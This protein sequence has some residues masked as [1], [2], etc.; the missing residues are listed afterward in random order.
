[1][2]NNNEFNPTGKTVVVYVQKEVKIDRNSSVHASIYS[3]KDMKV[4]GKKNAVTDMKGLFI[5]PKVTSTYTH[6]N[7]DTICNSCQNSYNKVEADPIAEDIEG[8]EEVNNVKLIVYPTPNR[9]DFGVDVYSI[10]DG[11]VSV[12]VYDLTGK[13]VFNSG[14]M[15]LVGPT[16]IPIKLENVAKATYYVRTVVNGKIYVKPVIINPTAR[17]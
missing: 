1:M 14:E 5:A 11:T 12:M 16:Y 17:F 6:W 7:W 8:L 13:V 10:N 4:H 9:G 2:K 3:L 15:E